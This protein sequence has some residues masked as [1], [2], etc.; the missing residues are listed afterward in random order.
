[1]DEKELKNARFYALKVIDFRPRS[2]EELRGKLEA[3]GYPKEINEQVI[4]EFGKKGLLNDAKFSKLWV[5]SR[6]A[7]SPKA[8]SVLKREL[9]EKGVSEEV[10]SRVIEESRRGQNEYDTVKLLA[11]KRMVHLKDLNTTTIKRRLFGFLK[12]R[13][14]STE[15]VMKVINEV[16]SANGDEIT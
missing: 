13:G 8:G 10:I 7:S 9:K 16:I 1:M 4:E 3:K 11:N 12:R 2:V 6:M 14:F 15:L 5:E